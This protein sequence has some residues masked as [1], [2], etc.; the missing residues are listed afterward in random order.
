MKRGANS[1]FGVRA[2]TPGLRRNPPPTIPIVR[3]VAH[4]MAM[5]VGVFAGGP[6]ANAR[7]LVTIRNPRPGNDVPRETLAVTNGFGPAFPDYPRAQRT[8]RA[9]PSLRRRP[10][11]PGRERCAQARSGHGCRE[12]ARTRH[13]PLQLRQRASRSAP[14]LGSVGRPVTPPDPAQWR[15]RAAGSNATIGPGSLCPR[16]AG[17]CHRCA[18]DHPCSRSTD[19]R[20]FAASIT[21]DALAVPPPRSAGAPRHRPLFL[22]L[23]RRLP[24]KRQ[25]NASGP[26]DGSRGPELTQRNQIVIL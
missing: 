16:I 18:P 7:P 14:P 13:R 17:R 9:S 4:A 24:P 15:L 12:G 26:R 20:A 23:V 25:A 21:C 5:R 2:A 6:A 8:A 19:P 22:L 3:P 1:P 11:P 10:P